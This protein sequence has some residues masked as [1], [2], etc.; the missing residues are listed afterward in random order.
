MRIATNS[1]KLDISSELSTQKIAKNLSKILK[2]NDVVLLYGEM[3]VGK[4][5]FVRNLINNLQKINKLELTEIPSP[6]FSIV[7]EYQVADL[8]I[9]HYDLH[10]LKHVEELKNLGL[11]ENRSNF[12][13]IIEWPQILK[14]KL[15]DSINL[16][17]EY[18]HDFTK[19]FLKIKGLNKKIYEKVTIK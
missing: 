17:F 10:R 1:S 6:T 15:I 13:K 5:T 12:I 7:N 3:G 19:R 16:Y 4:T 2:L 14:N 11:F 9:Q 18:N 8:N